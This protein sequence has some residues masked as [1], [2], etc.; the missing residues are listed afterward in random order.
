[1]TDPFEDIDDTETF[2]EDIAETVRPEGR[3][4][5]VP[6][7]SGL[8]VLRVRDYQNECVDCEFEAWREVDAIAIEVATGLGKT[9]IAAETIIRWPGQGRVLFLA[10]VTELIDQA[11][12]TIAK[13][14]DEIPGVEMGD[15]S[16]SKE[17]H[18]ILDKSKVLV[19]S[20]QSMSRRLVRFDPKHFDLIIIDEFHHGAAASYRKIWQYFKD[21]NPAIKLLGITATL[22]RNDDVALACM[23]Q[24][25]VFKRGIRDGI[26][27][28]W[29]VNV[30]Q[31]YIMVDNLDFSACRT[32]AKDLNEKDLEKAMMGGVVEDGM[33]DE[34]RRE[35]VIKQER[36]MHAVAAP[37]VEEASGRPSL[38]FC[39]TVDHA[40][41]MAEILRRYP[42]VTAEVIT[43]K[44]PKENRKDIIKNFRDGKI[45]FLVGVGC[46]LEGF[47]APH[48]QIV[49][50]ARPTKSKGLYIQM[51]GRATRPEEGLVDK[52]DT[53]E[54][55]VK[56]IATSVKP[57]A[58]VLD[59]CGNSGKH[60]LI[61]TADIFAGDMP[62]PFVDAA[63]KEMKKTGKA[64]D[65]RQAA[66]RKKT[67]H[68]EEVRKREQEKIRQAEERR[69]NAQAIEEARRA[70]LIAQAEYRA[71]NVD[72][73]GHESVPERVQPAFRGGST[74]GQIKY[75]INLGIPEEAAMK[76]SKGQAGAVISKLSAQTGPE[77]IMRFGKHRGKTLK[78]IP[79]D[80]LKWAATGI[81]DEN[82]QQNLEIYRQQVIRER[83]EK[84]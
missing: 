69:K 5:L 47:D 46:F 21:G 12:R 45:Q 13:H 19:A 62:A 9:V 35:V 61:S 63:V 26:D 67:E 80:Y 83:R 76:F 81:S 1:M 57:W 31:K 52:F 34:E 17:G 66:W 75:L 2:L 37:S 32:I 59:F 22:F 14:T 41:R 15:E 43:G 79:F 29:L 55:R 48:V 4:D 24:R 30:K 77:F 73:F 51:V 54:A 64:E 84:K 58:T 53:S 65:I 60:K 25:E 28:G 49:V 68:D 74:D 6:L 33:T 23:A 44:T 56:A 18:G 72:A 8:G 7:A 3:A 20:V 70:K 16:E 38:V 82:F 10:H 36:M 39:V 11:A 42:N 27:D 40:T 50:M 71:K 78:Q